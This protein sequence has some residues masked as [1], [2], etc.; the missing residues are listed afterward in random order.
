MLAADPAARSA[1]GQ[2]TM[3]EAA[4]ELAFAGLLFSIAY[5]PP[6]PVVLWSEFMPHRWHGMDVPGSRF[7][8]DNADNIYRIIFIDDQ[9]EY[10]IQIAPQGPTPAQLSME[11]LDSAPGTMNNMGTQLAIL[12]TSTLVRDADGGFVITVGPRAGDSNHFQAPP[13]ARAIW[14]RDTLSDW[15]TQAPHAI[16]VVVTSGPASEP[17][18]DEQLAARAAPEMVRFARYWLDFYRAY[19]GPSGPF[20]G[21]VNN[22]PQ[23]HA[24]TGDPA[25]GGGGAWGYVSGTQ[26]KISDDQAFVFTMEDMAA[27]YVG[28]GFASPWWVT[29]DY[30]RRSGSIN[31]GQARRNP[32]G[33]IT[34]AVARKDPGI[35]NWIDTAGLD[36][37]ALLL[38]WQA[39]EGPLP[40][41][42]SLTLQGEIIKNEGAEMRV[43]KEARVLPIG[44]VRTA[45][46][47]LI[48]GQEAR[49]AELATRLAS[50]GRRLDSGGPR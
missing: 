8:L 36:E 38:R 14:I 39:I 48:A 30:A 9:H 34:Y 13:E 37:G 23:P 25:K 47:H 15:A 33:T 41:S 46:P 35:A 43:I 4:E 20:A 3:A 16:S 28:A 24:R 7:G 42:D 44:Q 5:D 17:A 19:M 1:S 2:A 32:D 50:Y 12:Q 26:V 21:S 22:P 31:N 40:K 29:V 18:S 6:R 27:R 49:A 10:R 11:L 45:Y